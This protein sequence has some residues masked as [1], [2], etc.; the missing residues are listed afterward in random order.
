MSLHDS[1]F[2]ANLRVSLRDQLIASG[3]PAEDAGTIADVACHAAQQALDTIERTVWQ[4]PDQRIG[5]TALGPALS[6]CLHRLTEML[7]ALKNTADACGM[8]SHTATL[9]VRP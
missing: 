8:P 7:Q 9:Q 6:L 3:I 1:F 4:H 2:D 5:Y